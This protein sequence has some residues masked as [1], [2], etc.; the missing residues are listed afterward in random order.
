MAVI[1]VT[2]EVLTA[3]A[4][5]VRSMKSQHDDIISK[6]TTLVRSLNET[7]KGE[8]QSAFVSKYESMQST[9]TSFSEM[10]EANGYCGERASG[11]RSVSEKCD[12][13]LQLRTIR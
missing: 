9:F 5:E 4:S 11:Y 6:L 8:A 13:E 3:K 10:L 1:Q 2:P 7:W 12:A